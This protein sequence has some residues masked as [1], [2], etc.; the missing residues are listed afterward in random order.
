[1]AKL[2]RIWATAAQIETQTLTRS[3]EYLKHLTSEIPRNNPLLDSMMFV[4]HNAAAWQEPADFA[5]EP[6]PVWH[7]DHAMI[8]NEAAKV[9][10][11]NILSKSK[12]SLGELRR[13]VDRE[14][15]EVTK[16][17]ESRKA[18]RE[19]RETKDEIEVARAVL[20]L[21]EQLYDVERRQV[22]AEVEV[23][24]ITSAVGDISIGAQAHNF[25]SQTFKIPTNCDLC[26]ERI[27]GLSAKG[28]D[29][30]DCGFT[31]H[32][33][34]E[35]KVPADCP[36]ETDKE[37]KKKLKAERQE[38]AHAA[39]PVDDPIPD[40]VASAAAPGALSRQDTVTS[41]NTMSSGYAASANRS[42]SGIS[43]HGAGDTADDA[44]APAKTKPK[45]GGNRLKA[46][47]PAAYIKDAGGSNG[48][49]T[50]GEKRAKM[51][52][53]YQANGDGEISVAEDAIVTI[54]EPDDGSG[55]MKVRNVSNSEVGLVPA[56]YA[57]AIISSS[58]SPSMSTSSHTN[59]DGRPESTYSASSASLAGSISGAIKKKQGP[60]VAPK[61]GAKKL[62]H[63]EALYAYEAR[64][65]SEHSMV[66][67]ER[68]VLVNKDTGDGWADVEKGGRVASVPANYLADV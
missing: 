66:E 28:F 39:H 68:F 55:W 19:G 67:G 20:T 52:Y 40:R 17:R 24:T 59:E 56:A 5:F 48:S 25:K 43:T 9:F 35:M 49:A 15:R 27:W 34:C 21:Q 18:I 2:N 37:A 62:Q 14:R 51:L 31:C 45:I 63:V 26:G 13:D 23:G 1:M 42:V 57:E 29:C 4:R 32:S 16:A 46:P 47:P 41:M 6:S 10:L 58:H 44:P 36:G 53:P 33:K 22:S 7:D 54:V 30:R 60:A 65:E 64:S 61:R 38:A 8:V 3:T 11:R 50:S 12:S